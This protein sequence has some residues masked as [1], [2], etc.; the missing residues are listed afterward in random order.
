MPRRALLPFLALGLVL[1][2]LPAALSKPGLPLALRG[3]EADHLGLA[4]SLLADGDTR[5]EARDAERVF[6]QF[7]FDAEIDFRL[8][9][10]PG[11]ARRFDAPILYPLLAAP[12]LALIGSNGLPVTNLAFLVGAIGLAALFLRRRGLEGSLYLAAPFALLSPALIYAFWMRPS[13]LLFLLGTAA[14]TEGWADD[15]RPLPLWR[16]AAAGAALGLAAAHLPYL[17]L[18]AAPLLWRLF[19]QERRGAAA[20]AG[21]LVAAGALLL[22]VQQMATGA[23]LAGREGQVYRFEKSSDE[24]WSQLGGAIAD[25]LPRPFTAERLAIAPIERRRGFLPYFPMALLALFLGRASRREAPLLLALAASLLLQPWAGELAPGLPM[26]PALLPLYPAFLV[27]VTRIPPLAVTCG[28]A[29][30][31]YLLGLQLFG[32][33]GSP[34]PDGGA[35]GHVRAFPFPYLPLDAEEIQ[36][37][38]GLIRMELSGDSPP[39]VF[40]APADQAKIGGRELWTYGGERAELYLESPQPLPEIVLQMR[41]VAIPHEIVLEHRGGREVYDFREPPAVSQRLLKLEGG[42]KLARGSYL[43]RLLVKS[44]RGAKPYWTGENESDDYIGAAIA[45]IGTPE[46]LARDLY[47]P[48]WQSCAYRA[49]APAGRQ[50]LALVGVKNGSRFTWPSRGAAR[51]RFASRWL[52]GEGRRLYDNAYRAPLLHPLAPGGEVTQW[53]R[54]ETPAAPGTYI[55]EFDAVYENVAWFSDRKGETCRQTVEVFSPLP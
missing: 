20:F 9:E 16:R 7:P 3:D 35:H 28:A 31:T 44:Q 4:Y 47:H 52:D 22:A 5:F 45:L 1:I 11:G 17:L 33:L 50:G 29:A 27:L 6:G 48:E 37:G 53:L 41:S 25:P 54:V 34:I 2:A 23:P 49:E 55:L 30:A 43:Y 13:A 51:I 39:P 46:E 38:S 19:R 26:N 8:L 18:L 14:F 15:G 40:W 12:A 32:V 24:P 21:A 42:E 10:D 36:P